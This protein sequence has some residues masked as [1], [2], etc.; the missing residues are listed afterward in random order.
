MGQCSTDASWQPAVNHVLAVSKPAVRSCFRAGRRRRYAK[1]KTKTCQNSFIRGVSQLRQASPFQL[2]RVL[3]GALSAVTN[4][5]ALTPAPGGDL[6]L[7]PGCSW[8]V[9]LSATGG[10]SGSV[11]GLGHGWAKPRFYLLPRRRRASRKYL[12]DAYKCDL[13]FFKQRR[14]RPLLQRTDRCDGR[15][16]LVKCAMNKC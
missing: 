11:G 12:P 9:S 15:E 14:P 5:S 8:P 7:S 6:P 2:L 1:T 10:P 4:R 13:G 3:V 16:Y